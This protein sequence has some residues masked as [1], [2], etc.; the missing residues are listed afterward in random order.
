MRV[1]ATRTSPKGPF[2]WLT[3]QLLATT[4]LGSKIAGDDRRR[5]EMVVR[6]TVRLALRQAGLEQDGISAAELRV[7]VDRVL[8]GLLTA[9]GLSDAEAICRSLALEIENQDFAEEKREDLLGS[10]LDRAGR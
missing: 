3:D 5:R 9:R 7:V 1:A 8:A 2:E 6:G 10:F 4:S